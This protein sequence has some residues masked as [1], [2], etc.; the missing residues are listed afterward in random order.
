MK[1]LRK[2]NT[3]LILFLLILTNCQQWYIVW[4]FATIMWQKPKMI[5]NIIWVSLI[6][7][8][9]NSI[10]MFKSEWFIYD[11]YFVGIIICLFMMWQIYEGDKE[12]S[13]VQKIFR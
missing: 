11:I 1:M 5:K 13:R 6:T 9:A 4:L 7:E 3:T 8:F 10:Y 12:K 2:Y